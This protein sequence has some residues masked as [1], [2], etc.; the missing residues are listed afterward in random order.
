MLV[1]AT[2]EN[3]EEDPKSRA[4]ADDPP[5][6]RRRTGWPAGKPSS[7]GQSATIGP[8]QML[9]LRGPVTRMKTI[10]FGRQSPNDTWVDSD[11]GPC[12]RKPEQSCEGHSKT[13]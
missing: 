10:R 11:D 12:T 7:R 1:S 8:A 3:L 9:Q 5:M 2:P 4:A 13:P 6:R